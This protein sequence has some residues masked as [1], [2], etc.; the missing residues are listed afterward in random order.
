MPDYKR[1][2]GGAK[3][4]IPDQNRIVMMKAFWKNQILAQSDDTIE[5][6]GNQYFPSE[7]INRKFLQPSDTHT[8]CPWKGTASY[9]HVVVGD[10]RNEDAAWYYPTPKDAAAEIKDYV[11]FWRGVEVVDASL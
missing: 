5:I 7:S 3:G 8:N 11:A 1:V 9:Y 10:E 6:E 4:T 2:V